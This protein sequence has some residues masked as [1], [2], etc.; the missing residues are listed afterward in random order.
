MDR[1]E[2]WVDQ[3]TDLSQTQWLAI[4]GALAADHRGTLVR[5]DARRAV[6]AALETGAL[7]LAAWYV[8]DALETAV[9][10]ISQGMP[11]CSR[12]ERGRFAVAHDAAQA[13]ALAQLAAPYLSNDTVDVLC[14]PFR[15]HGGEWKV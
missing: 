6:D 11:P 2:A 5:H 13:A 1:A 10:T 15:L 9:F 4:G 7:R 12:D 3:L 8:R 14:A